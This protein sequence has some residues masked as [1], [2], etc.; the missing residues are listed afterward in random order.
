M[1]SGKC[2]SNYDVT[3]NNTHLRTTTILYSDWLRAFL[4]NDY[5]RLDVVMEGAYTK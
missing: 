1:K 5:E 2:K 4:V 3:Y